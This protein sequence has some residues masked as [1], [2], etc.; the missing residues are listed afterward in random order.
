[1]KLAYVSLI[2]L[3]LVACSGKGGKQKGANS[4]S[5]TDV[6]NRA[7][8]TDEAAEAGKA[9]AEI[10]DDVF[11]WY[12]KAE[13]AKTEQG[14]SPNFDAYYTSASYKA[15]LQKVLDK[16]QQLAAKSEVGFF[17][18][19]HWICGQDYQGLTFAVVR[20]KKV[21][22][23]LCR[24]EADVTNCG[25]TQR[26]ALTMVYE[27]GVWKIDDFIRDGQSEKQRMQEYIKE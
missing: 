17:D 18:Y 1:M 2:A 6:S 14:D 8:T 15:L 5:T 21:C 7:T 27:N 23:G 22:D 10:Y 3:S 20:S 19:D 24:I 4:D 13:Q 25:Q 9:T 11:S 16:D 26:I 12:K